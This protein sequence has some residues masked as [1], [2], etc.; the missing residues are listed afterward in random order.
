MATLHAERFPGETPAYRKARDRLLKAERKLHHQVLAVAELRRGLPEGGIVQDY[1][2]EEGAADPADRTEAHPVRLSELFDPGKHTLVLYSYMYGPK[3]AQ[4]CPMCSSFL[5]GLNGNAAH[6]RQRVSLAVSA[7]SPVQR[8][9][10]VARERGWSQLRL[11]SS[12][13]NTYTRDYHGEA[14]DGDQIPMLNVF[15]RSGGKIRHFYGSEGALAPE[16]GHDPCHLDLMWPLWNVL[17]L[18]P[19]GRGD[20]YPKLNY[21]A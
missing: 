17:D 12:A 16:P 11:I 18:T 6:I 8:I 15:T 9:R 13:N 7:K 20:W 3:M 4:P 2:F 5:D 19:E 10:D 14:A 21:K 1:V